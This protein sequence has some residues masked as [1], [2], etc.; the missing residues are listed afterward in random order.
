[1]FKTKKLFL[2][3]ILGIMTAILF[4]F[5]V[6]FSMPEKKAS[7]ETTMSLENWTLA[8]EGTSE[9]RVQNGTTYWTANTNDV[10][11]ASMLDYTEINGKTLS[12][13]NVEKPGAIKVTLQP[14]GGTIGSFY[15]III[16]T[17]VAGFTV[18][19]IEKFEIKAGWSHTD[20]SGTYTIN[21]KIE[22]VK[23]GS[24]F[25][26]VLSTVDISNSFKLMVTDHGTG[27][28]GTAC[29]YLYTGNTL[30]WKQQYNNAG[31]YAINESEWKG[32]GDVSKQGGAIQMSYLAVNGTSVYDIN[33]SDNNSYGSTQDAIA[34]GGK[35]A[36]ILAYLTCNNE[37]NLGNII[38]LQIPAKYP[39]GA[40]TA[41][42]NHKSIAIKKGFFV[43]DTST[44]IKY[45]V[46]RDVQWDYVGGEWV[47]RVQEIKTNVT[48]AT[49][50][51]EN[52]TS[53][54]VGIALEGSDYASAPDTYA[55]T[56]QTALSY[57]QQTDFLSHILLDGI[58]LGTPGE[59][60]LNVWRNF[61][62]FTFRPSKIEV[63]T[64]TVLAGC[65]FPTY[66]A[67]LTGAKEVY[68]TTEDVTFVKG[69][70]G[71]WTL[72]E[73]FVTGEYATSVKEICYA[74]D[75]KTNWMM[76]KLSNKDYPSASTNYNIGITEE[77]MSALNLYDKIIVDG[78]SLRTRINKHGNPVEAPKINLWVADCIGIRVSGAEGAL[79]GA[80]KVIIKAG[81]QF[82]SYAYVTEG[83]ETYYVTTEEFTFVNVGDSN[84]VWE[85]QYT[86][87]FV[88]DGEVVEKIPYLISEGFT[89][90]EVPKKE[91]YN[92]K[93]EAYTA[94][95]NIT[96]NAVYREITFEYEDTSVS[97]FKWDGDGSSYVTFYLT[98]G[99]NVPKMYGD[100]TSYKL[101]IY[102]LWDE[103]LVTA[104]DG[105]QYTLGQV[106]AGDGGDSW[107]ISFG[108]QPSFL[109]KL[110]NDY[111]KNSTNPIQEVFIPK[112]TEFPSFDYYGTKAYVTTV[113]TLCTYNE[114][115]NT[116]TRTVIEESGAQQP[117]GFDDHYILSDLHNLAYKKTDVLKDGIE[118]LT[119][120][121]Y[122]NEADKEKNYHYGRVDSKSFTLSFDF[123]YTGA[124]YYNA[125]VVNLGMDGYGGIK[126][127]FGWRIFLTRGE[128][129]VTSQNQ[130][131]Q[132]F[133]AV[134]DTSKYEKGNIA[135]IQLNGSAFEEG[136]VY[137]V[138]IGYKLVD[139]NTVTTTVWFDGLEVNTLTYEIGGT[140]SIYS[141]NLD[142]ITFTAEAGFGGTVTISD[143]DKDM[144]AATYKLTIENGKTVE[145][146]YES[147]YT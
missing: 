137:N 59:A 111:R 141:N 80:Q 119:Y 78:Y 127:G 25:I 93:W 91:G 96:V 146:V 88:A 69:S 58:K 30:Y 35:Y 121:E 20:S 45:E 103:V 61:G 124:N 102:N 113:D 120:T 40:G 72:D 67:L 34:Q 52:D 140:F 57:A 95:G 41:A 77:K 31:A 15:R 147:A 129:G 33:A 136:K 48:H 84:G 85:R 123:K 132:F 122:Q 114:S 92:A 47:E 135:A 5:G 18:Q 60:F 56:V 73:N 13:I 62:Y 11:T 145:S 70:D 12:Q 23:M 82:P 130:C 29:Y 8:V 9:F 19:T 37:S 36:P 133:S 104:K 116:W 7:A 16:D 87:T 138:M 97:S 112:G 26:R 3:A 75:D 90:P 55:G 27:A 4:C 50:F 109:L 63:S 44:N 110:A 17:Q 76:F 86:A 98:N 89:A 22:F 54:F 43:V 39:A 126:T 99:E 65:K 83:T 143:P 66:N 10:T 38:K 71:T 46:T 24:S 118:A 100:Y 125:F 81:A 42:D 51:A 117:T 14:A 131:V 101:N 74:R 28:N 49:M 79:D 2:T 139:A 108:N 144:D 53:K 21:D 94:N 134:C 105:N 6:V 128:N 142:T 115:T 1:V 64:I 32:V 68:V 107:Y 106:Y